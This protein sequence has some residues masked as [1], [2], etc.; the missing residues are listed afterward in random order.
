[1]STPAVTQDAPAVSERNSNFLPTDRDYLLTGKLPAETK[2]TPAVSTEVEEKPADTE[3]ASAALDSEL[4]AASE[5]AEPQEKK[6]TQ[7]KTQQ[8][9]ESRWAKITRENKELRERIARIEG[10]QSVTQRETKQVPQ[11]AAEAKATEPQLQDKDDKGEFKYKTLDEYNAAVR[12]YDRE[13]I[14]AQ[15][16]EEQAK[17]EKE[18]ELAQAKETIQREVAQ[19]VTKARKDHPDYDAITSEAVARKTDSGQD[20]VYIRE[21]SAVD[22]YIL[23]RPRGHDVLYEICKNPDQHAHIF[24]HD[25]QGKYGMDP[26]SQIAELAA[27]EHGLNTVEK[28]APAKPVTQAARPPHQVSGK[29]TVSKDAVEQAVTDNDSDSY[30]RETNARIL[31]RRKQGK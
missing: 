11:P 30:I 8:S 12:K 3:G 23:R 15:F 18:R 13:H 21:G 24:V 10:A 9:S 19:R 17:S 25:A 31:A 7:L 22:E 29:G 2:E 4:D 6:E 26:V 28:P 1:M 5:A 14:L 16:K 27:I 20:V